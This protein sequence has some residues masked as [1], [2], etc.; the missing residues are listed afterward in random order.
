MGLGFGVRMR[1]RAEVRGRVH[2]VSPTGV[3]V[4]CVFT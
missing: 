4:P 3:E 1:V 2:G